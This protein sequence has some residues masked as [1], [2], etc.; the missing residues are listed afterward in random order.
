MLAFKQ[1]ETI[2]YTFTLPSGYVKGPLPY[3]FPKGVQINIVVYALGN[4]T[5]EVCFILT[6]TFGGIIIDKSGTTFYANTLLASFCIEC[7]K[8]SSMRILP[9]GTEVR[10]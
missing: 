8:S 10:A 2:L 5:N 6:D 3:S 4:K 9:D 7:L 1:N